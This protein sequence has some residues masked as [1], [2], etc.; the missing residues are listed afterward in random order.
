MADSV[1]QR[2][3]RRHTLTPIPADKETAVTNIGSTPASMAMNT[4]TPPATD[5]MT[6]NGFH[7]RGSLYEFISRVKIF[8]TF[9]TD[10]DIHVADI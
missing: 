5:K 3:V 10:G 1:C 9:I 8:S 7:H 2:R 6:R 4:R